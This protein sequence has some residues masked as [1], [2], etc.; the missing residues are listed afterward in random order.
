MVV[1]GMRSLTQKQSSILL[2]LGASIALMYLI[3]IVIAPATPSHTPIPNIS[4]EPISDSIQMKWNETPPHLLIFLGPSYIHDRS[5]LQAIQS[6]QQAIMQSPGWT[7]QII[8][9]TDSTNNQKTID[10]F[11]ETSAF[12][13]NITAILLIGEDILL[14]VKTTY[15]TIIKPNLTLYSTI[16]NSTI[17]QHICTSLLYPTP[18]SSYQTKQQEIITTLHRFTN[19]RILTLSQQSAIIE[20]STLSVY[21][22]KDYKKLA[23]SL[24]ASYQHDFD[25]NQLS[26]LFDSSYDLLCFHGHGQPQRLSL[27]SS[28]NLKLTSEIASTLPTT[29]LSIDGCYTDSIYENQ[30]RSPVPFIS[31]ICRSNTMHLGFYGLL[32]QQTTSQSQNVVNSI[33]SDIQNNATIAE[34]I[35]QAS[36]SFEFVF[37][38]D[39][40]VQIIS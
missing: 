31:S 18:T 11:I 39:P 19:K 29:I 17:P 9:L 37:T 38:G 36:I 7:S 4:S 23:Q 21:S 22:E 33:L 15:Q 27:N 2:F 24:S 40:S 30:S 1:E 28:A 12:H 3:P 6:Y 10:S 14:P 26:S 32:S 35:N 25:A 16:S 34:T 5:I 8:L 13:Q 20:Q